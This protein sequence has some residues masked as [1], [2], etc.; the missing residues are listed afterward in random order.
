MQSLTLKKPSRSLFDNRLFLIRTLLMAFHSILL[1]GFIGYQFVQPLFLNASSWIWAYLCL[2][3][4]FVL[5][6]KFFYSYGFNQINSKAQ[7]RPKKG[8]LESSLNLE[9]VLDT[10]LVTLCLSVVL[11]ALSSVLLF[12]Y[13]L[14]IFGAG[15]LGQYKGAFAQG[16]LVSFLFSCVLIFQ[17]AFAESYPSLVFAF[18]LNNI[19]FMT[20]AGLSG[21]FGATALKKDWLI[22]VWDK[23]SEELE[24]L[25]QLIV[26]NMNIGL[27]ILDEDM[28]I[29]HSNNQAL[30][31]LGLPN[32]FSAPIH[33]LFPK[34]RE[35]M[36]SSDMDLGRLH[37]KYQT[38]SG[39]KDIEVFVSPIKRTEANLT[40][41]FTGSE[42]LFQVDK[43]GDKNK[44]H[45]RKSLILFQDRTQAKEQ[46]KQQREKERLAGIGRMAVGIAHEIRNPLSSV[47]GSIQLLD[48]DNTKNK[49]ENKRLMDIGF[50]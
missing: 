29:I 12:L 14:S 19:G 42:T 43:T 33:K 45:K 4:C 23:V 40:S 48:L 37:L 7:G 36:I 26:E 1:V 9:V 39:T 11:P 20:V 10:I 27:F 35:K 22:G 25:N 30:K 49:A 50:A 8:F 28:H 32:G 46:E 5:D 24:N 6:F 2:F 41:F 15:L 3:I 18:V 47:G 17:P 31:L 13:I 34:I 38:N 44:I 21:F 16:F